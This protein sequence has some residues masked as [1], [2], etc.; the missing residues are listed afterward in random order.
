MVRS[1]LGSE[2]GG[3]LAVLDSLRLAADSA[4]DFSGKHSA[5]TT[6]T[7]LPP[8]LRPPL[9]R[10]HWL[11]TAGPVPSFH[12]GLS[13]LLI[14]PHS[15]STFPTSVLTALKFVS[16]NFSPRSRYNFPIPERDDSLGFKKKSE[17]LG[18]LENS[19]NHNLAL[20]YSQHSSYHLFTI[21]EI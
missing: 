19:P 15:L 1:Q 17:F 13:S 12:P 5:L 2:E 8:S 11:H 4:G 14:L 3:Q 21:V 18:V 7:Q 20:K 16:G 10:L 6:P 9:P